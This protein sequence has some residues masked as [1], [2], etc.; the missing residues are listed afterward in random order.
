MLWHYFV[1]LWWGLST[2][3]KETVWPCIFSCFF[4]KI[5]SYIIWHTISF[6]VISVIY[7]WTNQ[8][9]TWNLFFKKKKN[10]ILFSNRLTVREVVPVYAFGKAHALLI[11]VTSSLLLLVY[12]SPKSFSNRSLP[13]RRIH[14]K[15]F[16]KLRVSRGISREYH[17][18][19]IICEFKGFFN[20]LCHDC[21]RDTDRDVSTA[22]CRSSS[23]LQLFNNRRKLRR[24]KNIDREKSLLYFSTRSSGVAAR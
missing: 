18:R 19:K 20:H 21:R 1:A 14:A 4:L 12:S 2:H 11:V 16:L 10:D 22:Y 6:K 3:K 8:R 23:V 7:Y 15:A 17:I 9:Q 5:D 24:T 13:W